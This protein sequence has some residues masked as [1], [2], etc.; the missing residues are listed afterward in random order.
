MA[1]SFRITRDPGVARL[2]E[3]RSD[4]T[5]ITF[6]YA[7]TVRVEH[8]TGDERL[9]DLRWFFDSVPEVR[10]LWLEGKL[11]TGAKPQ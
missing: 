11:V 9:E 8:E 7:A 10:R 6:F 3:D 5:L 4:S 2:L 1:E